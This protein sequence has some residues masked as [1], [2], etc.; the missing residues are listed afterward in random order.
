MAA[1]GTCVAHVP[2]GPTV[3]RPG[4]RREIGFIGLLWAS[5]GLIIVSGWLF[6]PIRRCRAPARRRSFAG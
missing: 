5:G 6:D 4:L 3:R 1:T 2:L